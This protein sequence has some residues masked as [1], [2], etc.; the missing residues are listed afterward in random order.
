MGQVGG[1]EGEGQ[2]QVI[3]EGEQRATSPGCAVGEGRVRLGAETPNTLTLEVAA[4]QEGWLVVADVW[5]PGWVAEVD[6]RAAPLYRANYLFRAVPL[7]SGE[8]T[9]RL[10]YRPWSFYV[11]LSVS[12]LAAAGV[13]LGEIFGFNRSFGYNKLDETVA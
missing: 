8:H 4:G 2:G 9:V 6:N 12:L 10:V 1:G 3:L 13:V 5:Y 11:G 7:P